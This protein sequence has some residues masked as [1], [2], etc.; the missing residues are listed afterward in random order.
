MKSA[1]SV[2]LE[3]KKWIEIDRFM[4]KR[5]LKFS[6]IMTEIIEVGL[7]KVKKKYEK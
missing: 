6:Q 3:T 4:K 7:K 1:R 5:K 2:S